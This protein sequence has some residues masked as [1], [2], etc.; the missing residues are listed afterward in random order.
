MVVNVI[1][2]HFA[3][4]A[5]LLIQFAGFMTLLHFCYLYNKLNILASKL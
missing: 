3:V 5:T 4:Q 2:V 1:L